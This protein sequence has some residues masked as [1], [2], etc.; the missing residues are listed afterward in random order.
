LAAGFSEATIPAYRFCTFP[1]KFI[2]SLRE[3]RVARS[4]GVLMAWHVSGCVVIRKGP[5]LQRGQVTHLTDVQF[6]DAGLFVGLGLG[7]VV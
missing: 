3:L 1:D 7:S 6:H 2:R 5:L 4:V